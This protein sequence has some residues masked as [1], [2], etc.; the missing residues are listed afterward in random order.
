M[1][2]R[3]AALFLILGLCFKAEGFTKNQPADRPLLMVHYMPWYQAQPMRRWGW[4]WTMDHFNPDRMDASG[5]REIA[6]H[7]YPL[8]GP[9]DSNDEKILEYQVL[10]MKLS[11][12]DGLI[13]DWYGSE[14]FFDYA[15][16]NESTHKIFQFA[17]KA[18]LLFAVCYEDQTIKHMIDNGRFDASQAITHG[19]LAMG[20]LEDEWFVNDLYLKFDDKPVLLNFGPQY[21]FS[22][23]NWETLFSI[24]NES[25]H[26]FTLDNR[27]SPAATG[28][29]PWPPMSRAVNGI[30]STSALNQYLNSFYQKAAAWTYS[31]GGAFPGFHDIYAQAGLGFTYG[32]LDAADGQTFTSTLQKAID[33]NPDVIQIITWNDFGEGTNIEPT[34]EYGY[35][36]LEIIQNLRRTLIDTSFSYTA[37][38]LL[39]PLQIYELRLKYDN[40]DAKKFLL[41]EVFDAIIAGD[42]TTAKDILKT[43]GATTGVERN[44]SLPSGFSLEQNY[45]NPFPRSGSPFADNLQTTISYEL[46]KPGKV[47]LSIYNISGQLIKTLVDNNQSEGRH[48]VT[49]DAGRRAPGLYFYK[50]TFGNS[51]QIRKMVLIQ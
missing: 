8:T 31:I 28:A 20:Y 25:P 2:F 24:L 12:I 50:I 43:L 18:G 6:S 33:S 38:D 36:Y 11:G 42:L 4:H 39:L 44:E 17:E 30:L 51:T 49:W 48:A 5:R 16:I 29:F 10:L 34:F 27:V 37:D 23:S 14:D 22:S 26:L 32:F 46:E 35:K 15:L 40:D 7:F 41:D 45:P 19:W 13:A 3:R 1:M 21:F 47:N 9:Y